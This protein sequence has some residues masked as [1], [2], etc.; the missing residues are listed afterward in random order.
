MARLPSEKFLIQQ[1]G[2]NV[3]IF[4]DHTEREILRFIP[5]NHQ[6]VIKAQKEI[7]DSKEL[8]DEDRCFAHFWSG[9]FYAHAH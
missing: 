7:Y 5:S 6:S 9:Y 8:S 3:I 1:V 2:Q 4:E